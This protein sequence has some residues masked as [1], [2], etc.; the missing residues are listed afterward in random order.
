MSLVNQKQRLIDAQSDVQTTNFA[1]KRI[2][3]LEDGQL[4]DLVDTSLFSQTPEL[5]VPNA[6]AVALKERPELQSLSEGIKWPPQSEKLRL[7]VAFQRSRALEAGTNRGER[8]AHSI[9]AMTM[10]RL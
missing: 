1:L 6:V 2:L 8:L 7:H 3:N 5:D 9:P 4:I 10:R